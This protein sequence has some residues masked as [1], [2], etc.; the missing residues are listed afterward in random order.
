MTIKGF[1]NEDIEVSEFGEWVG[2]YYIDYKKDNPFD[3]KEAIIAHC[4]TLDKY[5]VY[6][7]VADDEVKINN[8]LEENRQLIEYLKE[9]INECKLSGNDE[10]YVRA[11]VYEEIL[12]KI[13]L[14]KREPNEESV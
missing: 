6:Q 5:D 1:E 12:N 9:Q 2:H 11:D 7:W 14:Y 13:E 3:F 8:L 4:R 10:D